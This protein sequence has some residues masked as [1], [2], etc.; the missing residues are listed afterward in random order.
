VSMGLRSKAF[1]LSA[2]MSTLVAAGCGYAMYASHAVLPRAVPR[3]QVGLA[4]A[5][6]AAIDGDRHRRFTDLRALQDDEYRRYWRFL[7][8]VRE[9]DPTIAL[10]GTVNYVARRTGSRSPSGLGAAQ[11]RPARR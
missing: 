7:R 11:R 8:S 1:L 3:R 2:A 6:A 4:K 10:L 5:L 9:S